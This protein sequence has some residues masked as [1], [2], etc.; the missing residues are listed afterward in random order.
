MIDKRKRKLLI[1]ECN[2]PKLEAQGLSFSEALIPS[3]SLVLPDRLTHLI[4]TEERDLSST[5][6]AEAK[7]KSDTYSVIAIIGHSNSTGIQ[8][9]EN[10]IN[11]VL[12]WETLSNWLKPFRPQKLFL[13]ACQ[14]G[15]TE[16]CSILFKTLPS[17]K[18]V[19]G[20]PVFLNKPEAM[21]I[22][23]YV[24]ADLLDP[25]TAAGMF[26][27]AQI[28]SILNKGF[29]WK[30]ARGEEADITRELTE[31]LIS[32]LQNLIRNR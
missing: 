6:F 18:E 3:A 9:D 28:I 30:M 26:P 12:K 23:G 7:Q 5:K 19:C 2:A 24:L 1:I 13:M 32:S 27:L 29:I 11:K 17:L 4:Q 14:G 16:V 20:S 10:A 21:I 31:K 25:E 15:K 22:A 8:F